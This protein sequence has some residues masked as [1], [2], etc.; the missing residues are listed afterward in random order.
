MSKRFL[1]LAVLPMFLFF[2]GACRQE[3]EAPPTATTSE[4]PGTTSPSDVSPISA[5]TWIDDV[6][7]GHEVGAD[8]AIPAGR[9]GDDFAAGQ[10]IHLSMGV[11]DAPANSAVKVI[12]YG[13][14]ETIIGEEQKNVE[15]GRK[16][17][18]FQSTNTSKWA[19]GDYRAEVWVGDE[20]V[21]TQQFQIVAKAKAGK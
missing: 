14:G 13:P 9:T 21:N 2:A 8:G 11:G 18:N 5:Q 10:T 12:W 19:R 17:L 7:I 6:T 20:K 1:V 16:Y 3:G 4:L 15:A